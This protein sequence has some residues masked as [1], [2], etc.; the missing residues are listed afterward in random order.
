MK[1]IGYRL[2][3]IWIKSGLYLYYG[4]IKVIGLEHL[5]KDRPVLFLPNHQSALMDVLLIVVDCNRKPFFLTRSDIFT[6]P[7]LKKF[8]AYLRMIPIYRIRDG[9]EALKNNQ[10]VFD[11]CADLFRKNHAIVMFPEANHNIKRR[12]RP[13]SKG[14]T[15]ILFNAIEKNQEQDI[16]MVP[17]GLNYLK[18]DGFPDKVTIIY[19]Q[20]ISAKLHYDS[21]N[22]PSSVNHIKKTVSDSLKTL[23]THIEDEKN[24]ESIV[25]R[26]NGNK[27]D[28]LNPQETNRH[29][30]LL[31]SADSSETKR[32][33]ENILNKIFK[34]FFVLL[35]FPIVL[36]WRK[37]ARPKVW[38]P[39]F[40]A[41]L[42]FGF[43]LI[44]YPIYY[45][46]LFGGIALIGNP[47]IALIS[48]FGLFLFNWAYVRWN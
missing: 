42:R 48:I 3:K 12:V 10:A 35:N 8:F 31:D 21:K 24:Y 18:N 32:S 13:L 37:W 17:V 26:L 36:L 15:R 25:A 6:K 19:G 30:G 43:A 44:T 1:N 2:L 27:V 41:T 29:I 14:F 38:E 40:M 7:L 4:K 45:S 22:V 23:T 16:H 46:I 5:P 20:S 39:E 28:Y 47:S 11:T 33:P 9:R 34:L